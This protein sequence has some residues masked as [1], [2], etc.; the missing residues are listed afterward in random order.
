MYFI[1]DVL[2]PKEVRVKPGQLQSLLD[3]ASAACPGV[4]VELE[5]GQLVLILGEQ[6]CPLSISQSSAKSTALVYHFRPFV[7]PPQQNSQ[8][9]IS[10][11]IS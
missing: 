3:C 2:P 4:R 11:P 7:V 1:R 9:P 8:Q 6:V 10:Q 5:Q